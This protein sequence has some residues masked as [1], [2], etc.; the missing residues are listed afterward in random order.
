MIT[1]KTRL[2]LLAFAAVAWRGLPGPVAP[3]AGEWGRTLKWA[4]GF[5]LAGFVALLVPGRATPKQ[6]AAEEALPQITAEP[7]SLE[8]YL[9]GLSTREKQMAADALGMYRNGKELPAPAPARRLYGKAEAPV[10]IV[11]W[12]DS[13]CPHCKTLVEA[14]AALKKRVPE[15]KMSLEVRQYPLD[16]ACNPSIPPQHTDGTGVR[17]MAARAQVCLESA[18][19]F[20]ELREKLF[21][22]QATLTAASVM[23]IASSGSVDRSQLEACLKSPDTQARI[24]EDV[25]YAKQHD[26]HGTP[27]VV[28]NGR[29]VLPSVPF[30]YVLAM[31]DGNANAPAFNVLPQPR[32]QQA[33]AH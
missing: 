22:A 17:C 28:V 2:Q 3:Q 19:D 5:A 9:Q 31:T 21:A 6:S 33:H 1:R 7:G 10:R 4:G 16:G 24:S 29:S 30:L 14:V 32:P 11:E 20:W 23:E 13:K 8:A 27:L 12:T 25:A 18:P 26:I 15:G